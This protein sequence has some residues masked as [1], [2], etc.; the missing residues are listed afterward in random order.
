MVDEEQQPD[1]C[2][3]GLDNTEDTG[4]EETCAGTDDTDG[5]KDSRRVILFIVNM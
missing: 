5:L 3:D 2:N 4:S 1:D